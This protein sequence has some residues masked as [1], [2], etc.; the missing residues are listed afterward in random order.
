METIIA[1]LNK[2]RDTLELR[3]L[4]SSL[5]EMIVE[6]SF[7][8][9]INSK[10]VAIVHE[11]SN[12]LIVN[13]LQYKQ[14]VNTNEKPII[15]EA[16]ISRKT[17]SISTN[18]SSAAISSNSRRNDSISSA[19]S[20]FP[21]VPH[22]LL[23]KALD[24]F[25]IATFSN[26]LNDPTL[27]SHTLG[28]QELYHGEWSR[29]FLRD[30]QGIQVYPDGKMYEGEWKN[31]LY[32]GHGKMAY[33]DGS[34]FEGSF[35]RGIRHGLGKFTTTS[36]IKIEGNWIRDKLHGFILTTWPSG[37]IYDGIFWKGVPKGYG[38]IVKNR[39]VIYCGFP[40]KEALINI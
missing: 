27:R 3:K 30:G 25:G 7:F 36:G 35:K 9:D 15:F 10:S 14:I 39:K 18:C 4:P 11:K 1:L 26:Y 34:I 28:T 12:T 24:V 29:D 16:L 2:G 22:N 38:K 40:L 5:H 17:F 19:I 21:S 8:H 31:D 20:L 33:Q 23:Q 6:F 32:Y 13:D 37:K